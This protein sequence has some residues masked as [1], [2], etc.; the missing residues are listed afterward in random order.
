[1]ALTETIK[2]GAVAT[3]DREANFHPEHWDRKIH[4]LEMGYPIL[5]LMKKK[6]KVDDPV[7]HF[8]EQPTMDRSID[9][10]DVYTDAGL[11]SAYAS[12]GVEGTTLYLAAT[13]A[14]AR[15]VRTNDS[16]TIITSSTGV[17]RSLQVLNVHVADDTTSYVAAR[18]EH[19]DTSNAL[20]EATP[21]A[22]LSSAWAEKSHTADGS[23]SEPYWWENYVQMFK[24]AAEMSDIEI[25][26]FERVDPNIWN[27]A[28][29]QALDRFNQSKYAAYLLGRKYRTTTAL[30]RLWKTYGFIPCYEDNEPNNVFDFKTDSDYSGD[31][32][33]QSGLDWLEKI[34]EVVSRK[35]EA[36][37]WTCILSSLA[38]RHFQQTIRDN[39]QYNFTFGENQYGMKVNKL[40]MPGGSWDFIVDGYFSQHA[41]LR[42]TAI[43]YQPH[44]WEERIFRPMKYEDDPLVNQ[45]I[46][47][48]TWSQISGTKWANLEAGAVLK[49]IGVTNTA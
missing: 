37:T 26:S 16:L 20:A 42:R 22:L 32:F 46:R 35:K 27:R 5:Q 28:R 25:R 48:G 12:G 8:S 4:R 23:Y 21:T 39:T 10:L 34:G 11:S 31:T 45:E 38:M 47:K 3:T 44:L 2:R 19:T 17:S 18:L 40:V 9:I 36:D 7:Y 29:S 33:T 6:Q 1:M 24:E 41:E 14:N 15:K 49:N 13:A 43:V 30:G